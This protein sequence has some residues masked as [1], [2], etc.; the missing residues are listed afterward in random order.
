M[1]GELESNSLGDSGSSA[2]EDEEEDPQ[3]DIK[4]SIEEIYSKLE[5]STFQGVFDN[6][7]SMTQ[8]RLREPT[9]RPV[10]KVRDEATNGLV[11]KIHDKVIALNKEVGG[12]EIWK[13]ITRDGLHYKLWGTEQ[14]VGHTDSGMYHIPVGGIEV[15][16]TDTLMNYQAIVNI[17]VQENSEQ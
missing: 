16:V 1:A 12:K 8:F 14:S 6:R 3:I 11:R 5:G 9:S 7:V 4:S 13:G 15:I 10:Y 2:T 17:T